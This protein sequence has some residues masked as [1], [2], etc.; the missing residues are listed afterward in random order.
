M[1]RRPRIVGLGL[2][3][4]VAA[5]VGCGDNLC[6]SGGCANGA[7]P[8]GGPFVATSIVFQPDWALHRGSIWLELEEAHPETNF[9][10]LRVMGD[11]LAAYGVAGRLRFDTSIT[12][13]TGVTAGD[14]LAGGEAEL[15]AA[16]AGNEQGGTFGVSRSLGERVAVPLTG[17]RA[18]GTLSFTVHGPGSTRIDSSRV[19]S[20]VIDERGRPV[21][22]TGWLGG[23]LLVR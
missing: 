5:L 15:L 22:V 6:P 9:F 11:E 8:D 14:G 21:T 3:A 19:R 16:A 1:S 7:R 12:E 2:V 17:D 18:I 23:T 4:A 10:T 20:L 13:V